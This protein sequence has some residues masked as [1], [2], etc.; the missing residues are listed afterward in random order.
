MSKQ[1]GQRQELQEIT[2]CTFKGEQ[3]GRGRED[4]TGDASVLVSNTP[5]FLSPTS[6]L[7]GIHI[8][9]A[10][11]RKDNTPCGQ[12]VYIDPLSAAALSCN[13]LERRSEMYI[14]RLDW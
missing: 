5:L 6:D 13:T 12:I 14:Q 1:E 2:L 11:N 7:H 10:G 9:T 3:G 4:G 8:T